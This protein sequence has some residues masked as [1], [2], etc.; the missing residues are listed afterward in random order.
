MNKL[1]LFTTLLFITIASAQS[2]FDKGY[3][4]GWIDGVCY[5]QPFNCMPG[6]IP[7]PP[8]PSL[9]E[10]NNSYKDGYLRGF[11]DGKSEN[12]DGDKN[13]TTKRRNIY[14]N[15]YTPI[16]L[17]LAVGLA[18]SRINSYSHRTSS[19]LENRKRFVN[20]KVK[21]LLMRTSKTF[22]KNAKEE[23]KDS[24]RNERKFDVNEAIE[25]DKLEDGWYEALIKKEVRYKEKDNEVFIKRYV[26]IIDNEIINYIGKSN[27]L[28]K[29]KGYY[30]E[31]FHYKVNFYFPDATSSPYIDLYIFNNK[32]EKKLPEFENPKILKFYTTSKIRGGE[33]SIY[34]KDH[35]MGAYINE[36][37][38]I[39]PSCIDSNDEG[40]IYLGAGKYDYY[41]FN[42]YS[43]WEGTFTINN[44]CN[45]LNL[46]I[47]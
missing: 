39:A 8:L 32:A 47:N 30:I 11:T 21:P 24:R 31:G 23:I 2:P 4:K 37:S 19:N 35:K 17:S 27:L 46:K 18:R 13:K 34:I 6:I 33:I 20:S 44:N 5:D 1:L 25:I 26:Q 43:F 3:E 22:E 10:D 36:T 40:K 14:E 38:N 45:R 7:I 42:D 12:S 9:Y 16:D 15:S 28:Y 41:A 29:V